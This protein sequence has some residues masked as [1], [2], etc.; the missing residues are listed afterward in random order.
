MDKDSK[1]LN[2]FLSEGERTDFLRCYALDPD[3]R[4]RIAKE[5]AKDSMWLGYNVAL[6]SRQIQEEYI[7]YMAH[8]ASFLKGKYPQKGWAR[9]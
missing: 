2:E 6:E 1:F 7:N 4:K 8:L 5:L 9:F 3:E